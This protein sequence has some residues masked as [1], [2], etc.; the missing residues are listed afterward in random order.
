MESY[1]EG[2]A[3]D[4]VGAGPKLLYDVPSLKI[5]EIYN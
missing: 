5:R 3:D 1:S 2:T 4:K